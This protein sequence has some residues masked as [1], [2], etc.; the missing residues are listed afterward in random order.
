MEE[1][2]EKPDLRVF[3]LIYQEMITAGSPVFTYEEP[4][5]HFS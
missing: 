3:F 4:N 5:P 2:D 1:P